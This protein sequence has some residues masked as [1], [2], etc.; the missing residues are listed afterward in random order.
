MKSVRYVCSI[1]R[2]NT[3]FKPWVGLLIAFDLFS[4]VVWRREVSIFCMQYL[5]GFKD[6]I[7]IPMTQKFC[8]YS[9]KI[10]VSFRNCISS[11]I[12]HRP[13]CNAQEYH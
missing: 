5:E 8:S 3:I 6:L 11:M 4:E 12:P 10:D 13:S 7:K 1:Q 2:R 9:F